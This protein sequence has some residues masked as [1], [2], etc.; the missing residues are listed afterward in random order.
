[1]DCVS[2]G[3]PMEMADDHGGGDIKS[4]YCKYCAPDGKLKNR[5]EIRSGW[6]NALM[7]MEEVSKEE[8][9]KR[10]DEQMPKMPAWREDA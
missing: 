6:I 4:Q 8:A 1:M 10:V 3:M 2:C 9:T 7:R 5:E